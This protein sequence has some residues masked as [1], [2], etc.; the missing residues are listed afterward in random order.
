MSIKTAIVVG[1]AVPL[2][3]LTFFIYGEMNAS[4][5]QQ[6]YFFSSLI[7]STVLYLVAVMITIVVIFDQKKYSEKQNTLLEEIHEHLLN[8]PKFY[9]DD[10]I[11]ILK[12]R[13][14]NGDISKGEFEEMKKSLEQIITSNKIKYFK[15]RIF[16]LMTN[17]DKIA[18]SV[19]IDIDLWIDYD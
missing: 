17:N 7:I 15:Q 10:P 6:K 13:Y 3:S 19:I 18:R 2:I 4:T 9:I 11:K 16:F 14:V 8:S 1:A 12:I 5:T